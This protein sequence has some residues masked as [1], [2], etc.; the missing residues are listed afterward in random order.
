MLQPPK[1]KNNATLLRFC[2]F[3]TFPAF[4]KSSQ[5][6]CQNAFKISFILDT[7][8]EPSKNRIFDGKKSPRWT[9]KFPFFLCRF[10]KS[11]KNA[12]Y[13]GLW[14]KMPL[15]SLQEPAKSLPGPSQEPFKS[16]QEAPCCLPRA[17]SEAPKSCPRAFKKLHAAFQ[18][19]S[20]RRPKGEKTPD[21]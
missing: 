9:H 20:L 8:L 15:G 21:T 4:R 10:K 14:S 11:S 6:R 5:N 17:V 13:D 18:E 1:I 12:S 19:L 7:L 3:L 2:S 16:P